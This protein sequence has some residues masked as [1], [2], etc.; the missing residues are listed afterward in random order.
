MDTEIKL[1][2]VQKAIQ[3][4]IEHFIDRMDNIGGYNRENKYSAC[5]GLMYCFK[6]NKSINT[7]GDLYDILLYGHADYNYGSEL[8]V[9]IHN[10][11]RKYGHYLEYEGQ[12]VYNIVE[13]K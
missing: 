8:Y 11:V 9:A 4:E 1:N 7:D 6:D 12:G 2:K 10:T 13:G 3:K 5:Y